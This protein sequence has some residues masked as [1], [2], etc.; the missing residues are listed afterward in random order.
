VVYFLFVIIK[1]F[2]HLLRLIRYKRKSAE[3]GFFEGGVTLSASFRQKGRHPQTSVGVRKPE[4]LPFRVVS[5]YPQ[6]I[7]WFC[8]KARVWRTDGQTDRQNYAS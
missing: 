4:W 5:K 6:C 3:V 2:R 1:L 8:H 7:V